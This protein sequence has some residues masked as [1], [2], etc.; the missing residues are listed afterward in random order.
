MFDT[1]PNC[2]H[3]K[4]DDE[5]REPLRFRENEKGKKEFEGADSINVK[6]KVDKSLGVPSKVESL[7][8][9]S[10]EAS[11]R[12]TR[13]IRALGIFLFSFLTYIIIGTL[14]LYQNLSTTDISACIQYGEGCGGNWFLRSVTVTCFVAGPI[15]SLMHAWREFVKSEF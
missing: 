7:L 2:K 14:A 12:T 6:E 15:L 1:C 10:I 13:A 11:N 5:P 4:P 8:A 3:G 9:Q